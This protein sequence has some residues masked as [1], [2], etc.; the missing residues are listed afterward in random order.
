MTA[1]EYLKKYFGYDEFR[2]LQEEIIN[3]LLAGQD[4]LVLMPT[5]GGKS[6][7]Y[8]LPALMLE[9]VTVVVSPLISLMKDQVDQLRANGIVAASLNSANSEEERLLMRRETLAGR[10]KLLYV[11]PER[12]LSDLPNLSREMKISLF[13]IDEAHCISQWGH[14]FRQEYTQMG[15]LKQLFPRVPIVALTATADKVTRDDILHQMGIA[16]AKVFQS[17]F[18][19]PNLSLTV[20][21]GYDSKQR[22]RA[23]LDFVQQHPN[24]CGIV[25]CLSRKN[26]ETVARMLELHHIPVA[27]YH[28]GMNAEERE[29][30]QQDFVNDRVQVVCATV[31]FGMGIN[32]SNVRYVI[33][34]NLPK[35]IENYYQEIGRAGRDGLPSDTLLFF[36]LQDVIQLRHFAEDSGQESIN[37]ERLDRMVEYAQSQVCRR[38]I[39]LNY[40]GE[41]SARDCGNCDVCKH[42]PQRF[43]ASR[44]VQMALSAV[45]RT[46]QKATLR[47]VCDILCGLFSPEIKAK[48]WDRLPTFAVG[49]DIPMRDWKDYISQMLQM[50]FVE[51][52]YDDQNRLRV[53]SLGAEVLYGRDRAMMVRP[54]E[55][56][57]ASPKPR[58]RAARKSALPQPVML[59]VEPTDGV[60]DPAL[61]ERLRQLRLKLANEQGFPP[62][63]VLSDKVLHQLATVRP[64]NEEVFGMVSGIGEFKKKKYGTVFVQAIREY[65]QSKA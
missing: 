62:Y 35:S 48:G 38:R 1:K 60:E 64:Q 63:I 22:Q 46:G 50:G 32:K 2:P 27:V 61:F 28:A 39:L 52:A 5:G 24:D 40:F 44:M 8:Q 57:A 65:L 25:Y 19:R 12:L 43:D 26:T 49:R 58:G 54:S 20:R 51:I 17:S 36:N 16:E 34:Y 59:T 3:H 33:H 29:R 7:C 9:G 10:L 21:T 6:L 13:A 31:A 45:V 11:S 18:D 47:Q 41:T 30:A 53:T 55:E 37:R 15:I 14:D 56:G 42:P 4:A 23:I